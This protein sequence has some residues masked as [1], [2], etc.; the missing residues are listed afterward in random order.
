M[1]N[2]GDGAKT[3]LNFNYTS[4]RTWVA[5]NYDDNNNLL[6]KTYLVEIQHIDNR[7]IYG[8]LTIPEGGGP[9]P[10]VVQLPPAG[11]NLN[12]QG[13]QNVSPSPDFS[14]RSEL[15]F[16]ILLFTML[17]LHKMTQ[18]LMHQTA[19]MIKILSTI[20]KQF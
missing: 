12:G 13:N 5:D 8:Y 16:F 7:T 2:F 18:M 15:F 14:D 20:S 11:N 9:F 3:E 17:I 10:A 19:L 1:F 4:N 6:S